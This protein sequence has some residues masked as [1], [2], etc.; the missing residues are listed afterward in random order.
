ML[1]NPKKKRFRKK[2]SYKVINKFLTSSMITCISCQIRISLVLGFF[3]IIECIFIAP[4]GISETFPLIE[5]A[6]IASYVQHRV[7]YTWTTNYLI[8]INVKIIIILPRHLYNFCTFSSRKFD[9][10]LCAQVYVL[11]NA[12]ILNLNLFLKLPNAY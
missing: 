7:Q 3:E 4:A 1:N 2:N 10:H 9:L 12:W 11:V 6:T 5:I 8:K